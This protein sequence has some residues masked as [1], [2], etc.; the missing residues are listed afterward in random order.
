MAGQGYMPMRENV[1]W[2]KTLCTV[3]THWLRPCSA[4]DRKWV[5]EKCEWVLRY[6]MSINIIYIIPI[7]VLD[8]KQIS[9]THLP[10]VPH[11]CVGKLSHY[12]FRQWLVAC[13]ATSHYL[14]QYWLFVYWTLGNKFQWILNRNT[15][16]FIHENAFKNVVCKMA[17][18]LSRGRWVN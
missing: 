3:F 10:L 7:I 8:N 18:I 16:V 12:W 2:E 11:I 15:K 17:A 9:L 14:N 5:L 4:I 1:T 13:S 6:Y